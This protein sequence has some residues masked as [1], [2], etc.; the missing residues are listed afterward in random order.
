M[1][2]AAA[3]G[4]PVPK[5]HVRKVAGQL[6]HA[7]CVYW[8][9]ARYVAPLWRAVDTGSSRVVVDRVAGLVEASSHWLGLLSDDARSGTALVPSAAAPFSLPRVSSR[10]D[11]AGATG[12]AI[13]MG[14]LV[15]WIPYAEGVDVAR[16]EADVRPFSIQGL[17]QLPWLA[18]AL[19]AGGALSGFQWSA[20]TDNLANVFAYA[21]GYSRDACM[22]A[23]MAA[24]QLAQE[25]H[26]FLLVPGWLPREFN[27]FMDAVSKAMTWDE[28]VAAVLR[29]PTFQ[30]ASVQIGF[31][32]TPGAA[33]RVVRSA[34]LTGT[35]ETVGTVTTDSNGR[36]SLLDGNPP[37]AGAYYRVVAN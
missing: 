23:V 22:A 8:S 10:S 34:S 17:E 28:A 35:Y 27:A 3:M 16:E 18:L 14:P 9:A 26:G 1:L 4:V 30:G 37:G 25:Q 24:V 19:L 12:C 5:D 20:L 21:K 7:V 2:R 6:V 15:L 13:T 11:A 32:G 29:T 31:T 36:G 33:Y